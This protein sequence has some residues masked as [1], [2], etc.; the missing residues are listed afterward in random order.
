MDTG[1]LGGGGGVATDSLCDAI[2]LSI[3]NQSG[4]TLKTA[5][6]EIIDY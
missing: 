4:L 2:Q 5:L 1:D 3:E 6:M